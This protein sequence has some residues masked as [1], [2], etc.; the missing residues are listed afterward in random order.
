M[1]KILLVLIITAAVSSLYKCST[2]VDIYADYKNITI[3]Y[4]LLNQQDDTT[5]IKI[6]KAFVGPGNALDIAKIPDSSNYSYKLDVTLT[7]RKQ[8]E[9]LAPLVFDTVTIHNKRAGDSIFYYPNQLMYFTTGK[10]DDEATYTLNIN[11]QGDTISSQTPLVEPFAITYPRN[12]IDFTVDTKTIDWNSAKNG[13]R[14]EIYYQFF[15]QELLPGSSDTTTKSLI[16]KVGVK[17][18]NTTTGG[19]KMNQLYIGDLF[20]SKLD[21]DLQ[22]GNNIKRWAGPVLVYVS[23]GS[24]ELNNYISINN[25]S[26][27]LL[28]DVPIYTNI[29]NG[30]G[31]LASRYTQTKETRLSV[32]SLEKL[33]K[34]YNLGFLYPTE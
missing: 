34:D 11:N 26:G 2:D 24:Q 5:F 6:T 33:V 22:K 18:S 31:I 20:Y 10:L 23:S 13:K 7:G 17:E 9:D 29:K 1:K 16:W 27:S 12:T 19:S 32:K 8:G 4:G 15:Y 3:V 21:S 14:Y 28:S 25:A 30:T